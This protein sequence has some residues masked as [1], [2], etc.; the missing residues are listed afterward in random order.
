MQSIADDKEL[1]RDCIKELS[2]ANRCW[3]SDE[4]EADWIEMYDGST[5]LS[6]T[7]SPNASNSNGLGTIQ[8][9]DDSKD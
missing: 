7:M 6:G 3:L 8:E 2:G 4:G 1:N 5:G 9:S